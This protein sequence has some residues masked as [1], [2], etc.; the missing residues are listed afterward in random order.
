MELLLGIA[1]GFYVG[2][3]FWLPIRS[4]AHVLMGRP[5][6]W[7]WQPEGSEFRFPWLGPVWDYRYGDQRNFDVLVAV[8]PLNMALRA[9]II[10]K[11]W[12]REHSRFG[13]IRYW[14]KKRHETHVD[15]CLSCNKYHSVFGRCRPEDLVKAMEKR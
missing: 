10:A 1:I 14:S 3:M 4:W 8:I 9:L 6:L 15:R 7:D 13:P 2:T 5:W 12:V 11:H